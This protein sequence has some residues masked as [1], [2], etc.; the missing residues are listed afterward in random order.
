MIKTATIFLLI[1]Y[2][3]LTQ[4]N[5]QLLSKPNQQLIFQQ[6]QLNNEE[7]TLTALNE[8][9]LKCTS[10][11]NL[12]QCDAC[13]LC[14]NGAMCIKNS[15]NKFNPNVSGRAQSSPFK[16]AKNSTLN[17][18][19]NIAEITCY[20]VPGFTGRFCQIDIDECL[21]NPCPRNATCINLINTYDC[22]CRAGF[23]G[24]NCEININECESN[25]CNEQGGQ[26]VDMVDGY[27]CQCK[28]GFTG[29][30]CSINIDEC[31][32]NPCTNNSTCVDLINGFKCEC[33]Q[34]GY[35]GRHCEINI[36]D[37]L[38]VKCEHNATCIDGVNSF[39]CMCH[40]GYEG[41]YCELD[42]DECKSSP[43]INGKCWQNSDEASFLK[44]LI[45][46]QDDDQNERNMLSDANHQN[47]TS[48]DIHI[49]YKFDYAKAAGYWC[50][51]LPGK[52]NRNVIN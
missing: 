23:R 4:I 25:P 13:S 24:E 8:L 12:E 37:C 41:K 48:M 26:C 1:F 15:K 35:T 9:I 52:Y 20:C 22:K 28:P 21:A 16:T 18:V 49:R 10:E 17:L 38:G 11:G 34:S 32:S 7:F 27:Y 6:Q 45:L 43:C 19:Q 14:Q 31:E 42:I 5:S 47:S 40:H 51:C 39:R 3:H 36:D 46:V 33:G 44:K 29:T 30:T 2:L 50:E